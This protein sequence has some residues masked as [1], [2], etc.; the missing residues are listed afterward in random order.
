MRAKSYAAGKT[1]LETGQVRMILITIILVFL[2]ILVSTL[3]GQVF[4][5]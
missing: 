5:P 2:L 4:L 1:S 3:P